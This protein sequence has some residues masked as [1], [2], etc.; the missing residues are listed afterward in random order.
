[1]LEDEIFR[2]MHKF[3]T[4][5]QDKYWNYAMGGFNKSATEGIELGR[6]V[7]MNYSVLR[8][9]KNLI[10]LWGRKKKLTLSQAHSVWLL[11]TIYEARVLH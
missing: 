11:L 4:H 5:E 9:I 3:P 7:D 6:R 1:M 10:Q 8:L 2:I